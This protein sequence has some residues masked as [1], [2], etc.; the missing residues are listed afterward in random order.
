MIASANSIWF[1]AQTQSKSEVKASANLARQG[2][3]TYIPRYLKKVR[4]ARRVTATRAPLFPSYIFVKIDIEKQRWRAINS[5]I[6]ITRLIG[7]D[8]IPTPLAH[9]IVESLKKREDANGLLELASSATRFKTGDVVRV[10]GGAFD[11]CCGFFEVDADD[12]RVTILLE[13][14]GRKVRVEV[15]PDLIEMA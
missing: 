10:L 14:L 15:D 9:G 5:T 3:E 11:S 2:F 8:E 13:M 1:V 7:N 6:G 4:H 12:E